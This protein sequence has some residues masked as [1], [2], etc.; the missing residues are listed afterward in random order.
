MNISENKDGSTTDTA[1]FDLE[2]RIALF[3]AG[4]INQKLPLQFSTGQSWEAITGFCAKCHKT[5]KADMLCGTAT[6]TFKE[7]YALEAVGY[8]VECKICTCFKWNISKHG[9][10]GRNSEGEWVNWRSQ[11]EYWF[12]PILAKLVKIFKRQQ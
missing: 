11:T 10:S 4:P 2:K 5:I 9:V 1:P 7:V 6:E 8:C 12:T 3:K